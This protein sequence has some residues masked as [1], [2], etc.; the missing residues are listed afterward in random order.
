MENMRT[1]M[2]KQ[3]EDLDLLKGSHKDKKELFKLDVGALTHQ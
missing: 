3:S 2:P 1:T